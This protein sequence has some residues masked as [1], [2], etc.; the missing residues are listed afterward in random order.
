E[1]H[2]TGTTAGDA[3]EFAALRE[4]FGGARHADRADRADRAG[5]A[6]LQWCALGSV[7]SQVGHTK[8]TAGA[9]GMLKAVLALRQKVLPPT[10]KVDEPHPALGLDAS[11]FYLATAPRPWIRPP[12]GAA[13][14][15]RASV[16]SFGFGGT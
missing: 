12:G 4:V 11:P 1:A 10:I 15:R 7:K 16:S 6:D 9:A 5:R 14:P 2:G 13:H 8:A 3:A